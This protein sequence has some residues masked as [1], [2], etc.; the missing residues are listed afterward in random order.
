MTSK[1]NLKRIREIYLR[2]DNDDLDNTVSEDDKSGSDSDS[3]YC[4]SETESNDTSTDEYISKDDDSSDSYATDND[5]NINTQPDSLEKNGIRWTKECNTNHGRLRATNI[6]KKKSGAVTSVNT[7][8][9]AFKLFLIDEILDAIVLHTNNYARRYYNQLNQKRNAGI[10]KLKLIQWKELDRIEL[11]AFLGLLIQAGTAHMSH[12]SIDELW[13]ISKNC[14]LYHATMTLKR[15]QNLL[16]FI[17][18]DDRLKRNK[19]DR[20]API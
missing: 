16:R 19:S 9:D 13:D 2:N 11:E 7:I 10:Y 8:V 1:T 12:R 14:P 4:G 18:F 20:L 17:R 15:F 5:I 3:D 6:I